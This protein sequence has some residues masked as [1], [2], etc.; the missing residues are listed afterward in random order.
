MTT[1]WQYG[2]DV[3]VGYERDQLEA[4]K[5]HCQGY[6]MKVA[7]EENNMGFITINV[8]TDDRVLAEK[9]KLWSLIKNL[10]APLHQTEFN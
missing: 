8:S 5:A 9:F 2:F 3:S 7:D 10:P 6:N 1:Q 4:L